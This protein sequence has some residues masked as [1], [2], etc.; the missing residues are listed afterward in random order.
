MKKR[1]VVITGPA[2]VEKAMK[3][4]RDNEVEIILVPP[5]TDS[6]EIAS[7]VSKEEADAILVRMGDITDAVIEASPNLKVIAKHG[8]GV[9]NIDI[10]AATRQKIPVMITPGANS[11]SV[12]EHALAMILTLTKRI[13]S[14]D[15]NLRGGKWEKTTYR[16]TELTGK[17]LGVIG[18]GSIGRELVELVK[19]FKMTIFAYD[20]ALKKDD[21]PELVDDVELLYRNADV[22]SLHCPL[23]DAT[24]RM[25]GRNQFKIMK[26]T[27]YLVNTARGG[28]INED[29]LAWALENGVIAG[30]GLDSFEVEPPPTDTPLWQAPNLLV[31]PHVG[32]VTEES[33]TKMGVQAT[34]NILAVLNNQKLDNIC[35][36]NRQI[37]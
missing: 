13:V 20:P 29:D 10:N 37:I 19:P 12:A 11:R 4:L 16:G 27:A 9:N 1:K 34:S 23:T 21:C 35:F 2:I 5:Y 14:L 28:I 25:I 7:V 30:A 32:A 22:I 26:P 3:I 18:Y 24:R 36:V 33:L 15:A 17:C 31:S 6:H 8:V